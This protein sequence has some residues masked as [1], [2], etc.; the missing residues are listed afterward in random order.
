MQRTIS[1]S[2]QAILDLSM[3]QLNA[4]DASGSFS[5]GTSSVALLQPELRANIDSTK[6][7]RTI[8]IVS[9]T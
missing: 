8:R 6:M 1:V 2:G 7:T 9:R 4:P 3:E 5:V